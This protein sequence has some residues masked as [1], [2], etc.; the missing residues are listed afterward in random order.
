[1]KNI[2]ILT[3][4][5]TGSDEEQIIKYDTSIVNDKFFEIE[6]SLLADKY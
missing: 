3:K 1:M 5:V 2:L 4:N 6:L